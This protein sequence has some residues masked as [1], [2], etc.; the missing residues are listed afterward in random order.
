MQ[1]YA[2][3]GYWALL[4]L[5]IPGNF[6]SNNLWLAH[7]TTFYNNICAN[8][9]HYLAVKDRGKLVKVANLLLSAVI[10]HKQKY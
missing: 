9:I 7:G 1:C 4:L 8:K 5:L 10:R 3:I 6:G 2:S